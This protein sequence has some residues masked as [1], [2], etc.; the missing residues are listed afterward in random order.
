MENDLVETEIVIKVEINGELYKT[1]T[2]VT[3]GALENRTLQSLVEESLGRM[4]NLLERRGL[5]GK[6]LKHE[7]V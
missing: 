4:A 1:H 5:H 2:I 3:A 6:V 7:Q